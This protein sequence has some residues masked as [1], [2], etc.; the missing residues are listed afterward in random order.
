MLIEQKLFYNN[1]WKT[2]SK[3]L[4]ESE[5]CQ[6][7]FAFGHSDL[8][9]N[10][11]IYATISQAYPAA[12]VVYCSTAGEICCGKCFDHTLT[13]TAIKFERTTIQTI[14]T[15]ISDHRNSYDCGLYLR[16]AFE[17]NGLRCVFVISDGT[18]INGSDLVDGLNHA[19]TTGTL[20]TG[21]L[22]GDGARFEKTYTSLNSRPA[23]GNIIAIG[24]YG[25][26]IHFG[27]GSLGGWD[28]FGPQKKVTAAAKNILH[29]IDNR[30]ALDLYKEYL[31]PFKEELP[32]SALLFPISLTEPD[33]D[34]KVVRTILNIDEQRKS[35]TFAGN[36]PVGSK[37][38]LMKANF[39]KLID[40]S[41]TAAAATLAPGDD[42]PDLAILISCI[43][44]KLVL[45]DRVSEEIAAAKDKFGAATA[46]TGFYSYGEIAPLQHTSERCEL[47]NQ[48]MTITT[49]KES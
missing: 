42:Q 22:A 28:E 41:A 11:D 40:A 37:V 13:L 21:G 47:H 17:N 49:I 8:L 39:D 5:A 3:P 14:S 16:N 18:L 25:T 4:L 10:N 24:F 45:Q 23:P 36:M 35:M 32:G 44:R 31:G 48:T 46:I 12:S 2:V 20:I 6:L 34:R 27:H 30:S 38:R 19:N 33:N 29:E 7:V 9:N 15:N 26:H 43:G 1:D